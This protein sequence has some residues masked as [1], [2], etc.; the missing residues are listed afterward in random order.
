MLSGYLVISGRFSKFRHFPPLVVV[1]FI[2]SG[3][4]HPLQPICHVPHGSTQI[5]L[6]IIFQVNINPCLSPEINV[7]CI[8]EQGC[9]CQVVRDG[10]E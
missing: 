2:P 6:R 7:G 3:C 8:F 9:V 1:I 10:I 5:K 4:G